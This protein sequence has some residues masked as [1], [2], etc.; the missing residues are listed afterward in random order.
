MQLH[1]HSKCMIYRSKVWRESIIFIPNLS[2]CFVLYFIPPV[3]KTGEI[4]FLKDP[5]LNKIDYSNFNFL[6]YILILYF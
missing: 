5:I 1:S 2:S 6:F 3:V 4:Y